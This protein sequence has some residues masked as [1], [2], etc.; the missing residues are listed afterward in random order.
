[1]LGVDVDSPL[2]FDVA[3]ALRQRGCHFCARYLSLITPR[4]SRDLSIQE[5]SAILRTGLTL[6]PV[7][8]VLSGPPGGQK[9]FTD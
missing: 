9:P 6:I 3:Q 8:Q 1:M 2:S 5:A 7:Q 4:R